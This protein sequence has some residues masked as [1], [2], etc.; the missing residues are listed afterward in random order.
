MTETFKCECPTNFSLS[1]VLWDLFSIRGDKLKFVGLSRTARGRFGGLRVTIDYNSCGNQK[2]A[3]C[4]EV[5]T[6]N[7]SD[8]FRHSC[9]EVGWSRSTKSPKK[10][11][12][13]TN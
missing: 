10:S 8:N 9:G 1:L 5:S 3:L 4:L 11:R 13:C 7:T 6:S 2:P 12:K